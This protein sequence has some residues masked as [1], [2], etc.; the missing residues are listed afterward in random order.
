VTLHRLAPGTEE[1]GTVG[2]WSALRLISDERF[3]GILKHCRFT[4]K[5]QRPGFVPFN[6]ACLA[7]RLAA[8]WR[9]TPK[10]AMRELAQLAHELG[11]EVLEE[12]VLWLPEDEFESV[13][14]SD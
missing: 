12:E 10:A 13:W 7:T 2:R 4:S 9:I 3:R 14:L 8:H 5:G 6:A 11:G 1:A